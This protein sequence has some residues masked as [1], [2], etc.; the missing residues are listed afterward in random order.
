MQPDTALQASFLAGLAEVL[1]RPQ[2]PIPLH[3]PEFLGHEAAYVNECIETGW[4]SSVG[5]FVD[6]FEAMLAE[7]TGCK[8]AIA[9]CNG[10]ASLQVALHL[11]GVVPGDEVIVPALSFVATANAVA[12]CGAIPHFAES[13]ESTLG[14]CPRALDHHLSE[15]LEMRQGQPI[16]RHTGRRIAALVPMHTFGHPV[17]LDALQ[18]LG[19]R[20]AIPLVEDAAEALGSYYQGRHA[21][22]H[23]L[24]SVLSFNGN[25][26]VTTGGGGA[27][28]TNDSELAKRA[29]HLTTTAKVPHRWAFY[30]DE[31]AWNFR[32]PNLNAALGC[33]QLERLPDMLNDKRVLAQRY[34]QA[35]AGR[36]G[37]SFVAEPAHCLSN[38]WLNAV[39]IDQ[40][41]LHLRDALLDA[42]NAAGYQCRPAWNLLHTLPMYQHCP[43][44]DLTVA[45]RLQA[46]LI[47][48]PSSPALGR[49]T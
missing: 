42:A 20:Y 41:D 40:P 49:S 5:Q 48:L 13:N 3:A 12:H 26:V 37:L 15:T 30:H 36:S 46:S 2:Q 31:V 7:F 16:N 17:E 29:K 43:R 33:A 47:N 27:I 4:V 39:R 25:K 21:G 14:L 34:Q 18:A 9:V 28:L 1:G 38:Y 35:F 24:L 22:Q 44:A 23:G 45:E 8:H 6:R 10:T 32:L 11:A 19:A